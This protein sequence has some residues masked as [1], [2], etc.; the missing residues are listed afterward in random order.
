MRFRSV[1]LSGRRRWPGWKLG[2]GAVTVLMA[3]CT[4]LH[5]WVHN[6]LKVGPNFQP[7]SAASADQWVDAGNPRLSSSPPDPAW[8]GVFNDP[9]LTDLVT[10]AANENLTLKAAA[11]RVLQA[12][13]QRNVAAGN[14]FPQS[15][16]LQG[17]YLHTQLGPNGNFLGPLVGTPPAGSTGSSYINLW[18]TGFNASWELD[19][20]GRYRRTVESANAEVN[21]AVEGVHDAQVILTAD[22]V[23]NYVQVRTFQQRLTYARQNVEAQKGSLKIAEARLAEGRATGLDVAQAQANLAQTEA[24]I[25]PLEVGL[26]QA[27][28]RLCV[29]LGRPVT[30]LLPKLNQGPL[31]VAPPT[32]AVGIPAGLMERRPD[33]RRA[34]REAAVQSARIGVAEA[35]F[36]PSIGVTGFLGYGATDFRQLFAENSFTGLILPNFQWK[37]LNYGRILNN[38]RTQDA[39]LQ[40][41]ILDYQQTVLTAGRE[42]EDAQVGFVQYLLQVK[43]LERSVAAAERSVELVLEQYKEGRADFNR[44]FTTQAQLATQQDQLAAARGNAALNLVAIYRAL[45]GGWQ[46]FEQPVPAQLFPPAEGPPPFV[47]AK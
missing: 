33:V 20:W 11:T 13:A 44:V 27:S 32:V 26:R 25:P 24:T 23:S 41:R 12:R 47:E 34:L 14:L 46:A 30:D 15:Q 21:S 31:P 4:S 10:T 16:Q 45:G 29:L 3:G 36:Y 42:V 35:D 40:E 2:A 18:T 7:V 28:N 38:V 17:A 1:R 5:E 37:I 43:A 9:Q 8:W 19:F 22:V 39:R 6:G